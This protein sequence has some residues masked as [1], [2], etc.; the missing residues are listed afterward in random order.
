MFTG[1]RNAATQRPAARHVDLLKTPASC[2]KDSISPADAL[3]EVDRLGKQQRMPAQQSAVRAVLSA[4]ESHSLT[5]V[6]VNLVSAGIAEASVK[7]TGLHG[8]G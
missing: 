7:E 8:S 2:A 5:E 1:I 3:H 4:C 6:E